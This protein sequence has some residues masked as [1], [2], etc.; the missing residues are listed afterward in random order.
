VFF[1]F[2]YFFRYI[3]ENFIDISLVLCLILSFFLIFI[4]AISLRCWDVRPFVSDENSRCERLFDGVHH[5]AE[6]LLLRCAWSAD[7]QRVASGS[8]DR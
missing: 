8:A 1:L 7:E 3:D 6:K 2:K 4:F 5:G